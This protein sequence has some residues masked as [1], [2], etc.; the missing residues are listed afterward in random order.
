M[1]PSQDIDYK[2]KMNKNPKKAAE[3]YDDLSAFENRCSSSS[4]MPLILCD[5]PIFALPGLKILIVLSDA[6]LI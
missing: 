2:Y 4:F 3:N 1:G 6:L 5:D